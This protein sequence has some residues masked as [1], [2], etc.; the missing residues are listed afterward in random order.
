MK[1][2]EQMPHNGIEQM[3]KNPWGYSVKTEPGIKQSERSPKLALGSKAAIN[4]RLCMIKRSLPRCHF[5]W[6]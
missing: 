4:E 1:I 2:T 3:A 5:L 6:E